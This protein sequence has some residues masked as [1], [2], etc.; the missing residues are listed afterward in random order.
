V[1]QEVERSLEVFEPDG[2]RLEDG[3]EVL[4]FH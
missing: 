3:F 4:W 1:K 2:I